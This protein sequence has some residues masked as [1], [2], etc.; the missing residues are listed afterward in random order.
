LLLG[1]LLA[2]GPPAASLVLDG[3]TADAA[4]AVPIVDDAGGAALGAAVDQR[5]RAYA[6][7]G[8]QR[9]AALLEAAGSFGA[10]ADDLALSVDTRAQ[11][12]YRAGE[13]LRARKLSVEAAGRFRQALQLGGAVPIPVNDSSGS[14]TGQAELAGRPAREFAARGLLELAHLERRTRRFDE[15]LALY[16]RLGPEF[17]DQPRQGAHASTW[18]TKLL[19]RLDRLDEA[20]AASGAFFSLYPDL[21]LEFVRNA[22][23]VAEGLL[24]AGRRDAARSFLESVEGR[25]QALIE[26]EDLPVIGA[27][28]SVRVT[29]MN[30]GR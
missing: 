28:E 2:L 25:L 27:L 11:A 12:A 15:A 1:A 19:V 26:A 5:E 13:L 6:L 8:E 16:G 9:E 23:V 7:A 24:D 10:V 21:P 29:V 4:A 30:R 3:D 22:G 14:S 18:S 17:P 20:V